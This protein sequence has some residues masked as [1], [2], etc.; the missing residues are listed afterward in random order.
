[1]K[2]GR[3]V[4]AKGGKHSG[5]HADWKKQLSDDMSF[6]EKGEYW[7]DKSED[8]N[9]PKMKRRM[10]ELAEAY[11]RE[12]DIEEKEAEEEAA[13]EEEM[14]VSEKELEQIKEQIKLWGKRPKLWD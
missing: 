13:T 8:Q 1:M 9:D 4:F 2:K 14:H 10:E 3:F 5:E 12:A 11:I 6:R 7:D